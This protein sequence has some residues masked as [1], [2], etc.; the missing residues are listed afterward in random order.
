MP[1]FCSNSSVAFYFIQG[2]SQSHYVVYK[3]QSFWLLIISRTMRLPPDLLPLHSCSSKCQRFSHLEDLALVVLST[4]NSFPP[5]ICLAHSHLN[6]LSKCHSI[7]EG[8]LNYHSP[9]HY[10]STILFSISS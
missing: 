5:H 3:A 4:W 8:Y 2:K 9:F 6:F 10:S 7:N 1:L